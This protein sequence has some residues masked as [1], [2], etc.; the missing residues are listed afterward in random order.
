MRE[1]YYLAVLVSTHL[2]RFVS[3][4]VSVAFDDGTS[5]GQP[6]G[7]DGQYETTVTTPHFDPLSIEVDWKVLP[8]DL[9]HAILRLPYKVESLNRHISA[10]GEF[11]DPPDY[12]EFFWARQY[13]YAGLGLD[14]VQLS[15]TL[16]S[17][18]GLR[19][20][21]MSFDKDWSAERGLRDRK[22]VLEEARA[23]SQARCGTG[24]T[25][26]FVP[27]DVGSEK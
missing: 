6:A 15:R 23:A 9:M 17:H 7:G 21:P 25:G 11:D 16:L 8:Q 10:V 27:S 24:L 5:M 26:D 18:V 13:G 2:D 3:E 19:P 22:A 1:T 20:E 4:C 14:V 12:A